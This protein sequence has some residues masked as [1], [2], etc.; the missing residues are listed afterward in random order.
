MQWMPRRHILGR[1]RGHQPH[2]LIE[3]IRA[4]CLC[5]SASSRAH[6]AASSNATPL[7]ADR[8]PALKFHFDTSYGIPQL[9][10]PRVLPQDS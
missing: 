5:I 1:M 9:A 10:Q 2:H 4:H 3:R 7:Q 6:S 8:G